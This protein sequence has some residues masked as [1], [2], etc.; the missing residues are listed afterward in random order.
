MANILDYLRQIKD[1]VYGKDVRSSIY[2]ALY[3]MN[4]QIDKR[5]LTN[6]IV[7]NDEEDVTDN[8]ILH[9]TTD[10]DEIEVPTMDDVD[11]LKQDLSALEE[12]ISQGGSGLSDSAKAL[13]ITILRNAIY[14]TNQSDNI[15][16]MESALSGGDDTPTEP[17]TPTLTGITVT[18]SGDS[19]DIGTDPRTLISSVKANYSDGTSQTVTG[20]TV[21]PS[22]LVE[23]SQTITVTYNGKTA[24]KIITGN[25]AVVA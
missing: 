24:T 23:G 21:S 11:V 13:L 19:A 16:L 17:T 1:A 6:L 25:S 22:S 7:V 4:E 10:K 5:D 12:Q 18:W 20:Y 2:N 14:S 15:T 8:T 9:I 3:E